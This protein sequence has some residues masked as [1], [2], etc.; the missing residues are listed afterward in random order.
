[1]KIY[2]L[3][4]LAILLVLVG[5]GASSDTG[6]NVPMG[7]NWPVAINGTSPYES[8]SLTKQ[9]LPGKLILLGSGFSIGGKGVTLII[10]MANEGDTGRFETDIE[11]QL[12]GVPNV[13]HC[14]QELGAGESKVIV[15]ITDNSRELFIAKFEFNQVACLESADKISGSG[16]MTKKRKPRD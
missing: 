9:Y 13:G 1:M 3:A 8:S 2:L 7:G 11:F 16:V 12:I 10:P 14:E 5:C 4:S 6:D 15:D